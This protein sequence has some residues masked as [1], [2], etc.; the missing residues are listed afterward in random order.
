MLGSTLPSLYSLILWDSFQLLLRLHVLLIQ[1]LSTY[2]WLFWLWLLYWRFIFI[3]YCP[4]LLLCA[5]W[6]WLRLLLLFLKLN[7]V[8]LLL[9]FIILLI[10]LIVVQH[11]RGL[12]CSLLR[13]HIWARYVIL[14][15]TISTA[16][17]LNTWLYSI[18]LQLLLLLFS[19][20]LQLLLPLLSLLLLCLYQILLIILFPLRN[21]LLRCTRFLVVL[22]QSSSRIINLLNL[23]RRHGTLSLLRRRLR[24]RSSCT[25]I[26]SWTHLRLGCNHKLL[27][28][29]YSVAKVSSFLLH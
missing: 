6:F 28:P 17:R 29:C 26:V 2:D 24:L 27:R 1:I 15:C 21:Q 3:N 13:I 8:W 16:S 7:K 11:I 10:K 20:S 9:L 23:L 5:R 19:F 14:C 22:S 4:L 12:W 18:K 25:A